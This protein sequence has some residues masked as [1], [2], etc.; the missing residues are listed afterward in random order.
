M[1]I[2]EKYPDVMVD[3]VELDQEVI[4]VAERFSISN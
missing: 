2:R 3:A 4:N 1:A